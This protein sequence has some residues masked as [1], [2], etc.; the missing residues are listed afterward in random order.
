MDKMGLS[1]VKIFNPR[2]LKKVANEHIPVMK[3]RVEGG[4][5]GKG[6]RFKG[7]TRKYAEIKGRKFTSK[8]TGKR[9]KYPRGSISSTQTNPA[10]L[11]LTGLMLKGLQYKKSDKKSWTIGW[12]GQE[13][14][15]VSGNKDNGRDIT[16]DVPN[17]EKKF[18]VKRLEF[19]L[20]K[21][22]R[23]LKDVNITIG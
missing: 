9:Y 16:S 22:F 18:M 6:R 21:E 1:K 12:T 3:K 4:V 5:D 14:E 2:D 13:A 15:K 10:N 19:Y 17:K 20:G 11:T 8:K 23:K 7:Y